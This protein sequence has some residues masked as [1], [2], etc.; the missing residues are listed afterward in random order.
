[1]FKEEQEHDY[2]L[3]QLQVQIEELEQ[4]V[5]SLK[6]SNKKLKSGLKDSIKLNEGLVQKIKNYEQKLQELYK[7]IPNF[8]GTPYLHRSRTLISEKPFVPDTLNMFENE[9]EGYC[10]V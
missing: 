2:E 1:M 10:G 6:E 4:E 5:D 9:C 8:E 7:Q 3:E